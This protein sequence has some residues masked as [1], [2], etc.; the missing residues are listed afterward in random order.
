MEKELENELENPEKRKRESSPGGPLSPARPRAR[1]SA[2]PDRRTPPVSGSSPLPRAL[3]LALCPLGPIC[4]RQ[5]S[6][7]R[8][9]SFSLC[10]AD[11]DRQCR[12]VAPARPLFSLSA[13]WTLPVR[14]AFS[15]R[16]RG[17]A[18]A[19]SRTSPGFSATTPAHAPNSLLKAPLVPCTHPSPHFAH[20][21]PLSRSALAAS[22]RRRPVP[23]SPAIQLAGIRAK[24]PRAPPR[25][26]TPVPVPNFPY[27]A[28]CSSN[29]TLAGVWPWRS[30]VLARWPTNLARSSSPE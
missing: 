8:A 21:H 18:H 9:L 3:S 27:Y 6:I 25:G 13:P 16:R 23:A 12:A 7:A 22:R 5:F 2:P 26:V 1:T 20:S 10:L 14:S 15:A 11:L 4:R 28:L 17:P 24:P 30:A 29:F 19:H